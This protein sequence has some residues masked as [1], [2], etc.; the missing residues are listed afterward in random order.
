MKYTFILFQFCLCFWL[1][2]PDVWSQTPT[3]LAPDTTAQPPATIELAEVS[4]RSARVKIR[5][6]KSLE[7]LITEQELVQISRQN[8]SL[9]KTIDTLITKIE[10]VEIKEKN[11]RFL[12]KRRIQL[13]NIRTLIEKQEKYLSD[14]I[15]EYE[16]NKYDY[17]DEL[18]LW[19]N[20]KNKLKKNRP[21]KSIHERLLAVIEL[22]ENAEQQTTEKSNALLGLLD[23]TTEYGV[24]ME[25][26]LDDIDHYIKQNKEGMLMSEQ[27]TLFTMN[28]GDSS[29]W[30]I[31]PHLRQFYWSDIGELKE[32][33]LKHKSRITLSILL[34]LVI[35]N[36][37]LILHKR[38]KKTQR[39]PVIYYQRKLRRLLSFPI[40]IAIILS[41][42]LALPLLPNRPLILNDL[43]RIIIALPLLYILHTLL[44]GKYQKYIYITS[45][46]LGFY[47]IFLSLPTENIWHRILL[48]GFGSVELAVI[49]LFFMALRKKN[50]KTLRYGKWKLFFTGF[51]I[52]L[53]ILA[54]LGAITGGILLAETCALAVLYNVIAAAILI[55]ASLIILGL[56]VTFM[57]SKY[58]L[59]LNVVQEF[60]E[61][62]QKKSIVIIKGF[63]FTY[64]LFLMI[65]N[66]GFEENLLGSIQNLLETK[67]ELGS[68]V[69]TPGNLLIFILILYISAL[70]SKIIRNVLEKDVLDK[71]A[72]PKGI[73][74]TIGVM[75]RYT[76]IT[77]GLFLAISAAGM[78]FTS[79]TIIFASLSVGIGFGLQN[80]FN[81]LVS[82]LI[83]L[84]ER[85]IQ[86]GDIIEVGTLLGHVKSIGIRS[87]KVRTYDG[88]EVIVP[89][90][91][92]ISNEVVNWTLSDKRRRIEVLA[93]VAYGSDPHKAQSLF[94]K[95]LD[96]H[97]DVLKNPKPVVL[98]KDLGE[99]SLDFRLLFWTSNFE[100]WLRIKSEIVF[101][102]HDGLKTE[103]IEIPFPQRDLHIRSIEKTLHVNMKERPQK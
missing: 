71:L 19:L 99:S 44:P 59:Q 75:V 88:A 78:P 35:L 22:L 15:Q 45:I 73:P 6:R 13:L 17:Q 38:W 39:G 65:R 85:P 80:I 52:G 48:L 10:D 50:L 58:A 68:A 4:L 34:F 84:F 93:G 90:G 102:I 23:K 95:I 27:P 94:Q 37:F 79:L 29:N 98:F 12:E 69:I 20:T 74:H 100:E 8:D 5:T 43:I 64:F 14:M 61:Q 25:D 9:L 21:A 96:E 42:L 28:Y 16:S 81:N 40:S 31:R 49:S 92:L 89:N 30:M 11:R 86:L 54:I 7:K 67:W 32:Y 76:L 60:G 91:Q 36:A 41:I 2:K 24:E 101:R 103:G 66:L 56:L 77:G 70:L 72:L 3:V 57:N 46:L 83:L 51:H 62:V 26:R 33:L 18:E 53:S 87:S 82:G 1:I 97:P 55:V 63:V 47:L